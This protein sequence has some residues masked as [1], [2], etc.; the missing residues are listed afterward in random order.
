MP[1]PI[2]AS[3]E[4]TLNL[5][6]LAEASNEMRCI[7]RP[8]RGGKIS[9]GK[10]RQTIYAL[11]RGVAV[12]V[13]G[14]ALSLMAVAT[15]AG[16][17]G[18]QVMSGVGSISQSGSTT[19]ITQTSQNLSLNWISFNIQPTETVNFLQPSPI[20]VAV[21]RILGT[22]GTQIL[23]H[24]NANGQVFLINPNG[25]VFGP[26][27]V[28]NVGG[29]VASTLDLGDAGVADTKSFSGADTGRV[30]NQGTISASQGGYVALI[31]NHVS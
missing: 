12:L 20:A 31:G 3:N 15:R 29:L 2:K 26:T 27:A 21:N 9:G 11:S 6:N 7:Y 23:G 22:N 14:A 17:I 25:I 28:V 13:A 1:L 24:L 19:N 5:R 16:P 10:L 18:G 30:V 8:A 4:P